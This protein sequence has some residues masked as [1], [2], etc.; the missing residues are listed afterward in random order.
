MT[1]V[2]THPG[3]EAFYVL[4]GEQTLRTAAGEVRT[5]A[6]GMEVG[7]A[8]GTPLQVAST[9]ATDL[10]A[11]I[12]FVVDADQP[13]STPATI[14][15][16]FRRR[17][18]ALGRLDYHEDFIGPALVA[19]QQFTFDPGARAGW[20]THPGPAWIVVTK[21]EMAFYEAAGDGCRRTVYPAGSAIKEQAGRVHEPR[22]ETAELLEF[23]VTFIVPVGPVLRSS[24]EGPTAE[25]GG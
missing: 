21:G 12:M 8:S 5:A 19:V 3:S 7:A 17:E 16:S 2:H 25:C 24:A 15:P 4:A 11:L 6:G 22:N 1:P 14:A 20:H 9:G 13:F 23:Y 10:R 18:I